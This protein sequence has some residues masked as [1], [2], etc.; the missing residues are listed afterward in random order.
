MTTKV[1]KPKNSFSD[2]FK[3]ISKFIPNLE[4]FT[5]AKIELAE[6]EGSIDKGFYT[7]HDILDSVYLTV[8]KSYTKE[9]KKEALNKLLFQKVIS[10]IGKLKSSGKEFLNSISTTTILKEELD[11]LGEN[12]SVDA[13]GDFIPE[14]EFEDISYH[15]KDFKPTHFILEEGLE[16]NLIGKLFNED[17]G[18]SFSE[19]R[20][21]IPKIFH[22]FPS[23]T[24]I[25]LELYA[26]GDQSPKQISKILNLE[27]KE[28]NSVLKRF[29][30]EFTKKIIP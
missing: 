11:L 26:F 12:Y 15:Q 28:I 24:K 1:L 21:D 27:K 5:R 7:V 4:N 10:M 30:D 17:S 6:N 29:I 19:H 22:Y 20:K 13:G 18:S 3:K 25:S 23:Y 9:I 16:N 2:F 14:E 8:F